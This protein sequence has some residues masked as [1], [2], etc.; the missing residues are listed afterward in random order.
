MDKYGRAI[1]ELREKNRD[2]R[3]DLAKKLE[4]SESGLGKYERGERAIKPDLL[5]KVAKIYD[6]KVADLFGEDGVLPEEF[7]GIGVEWIRFAQKMKERDLTPEQIE[8]T[9]EFLDKMGLSKK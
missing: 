9:L 2:T 7:K 6:V 8:A 4:M 3:E 1:R 5:E